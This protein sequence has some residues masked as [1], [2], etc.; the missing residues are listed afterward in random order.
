MIAK[1][2]TPQNCPRIQDDKSKYCGFLDE[3][4]LI[5]H[6]HLIPINQL[7]QIIPR[8]IDN[9]NAKSSRT[10]LTLSETMT[11]EQIRTTYEKVGRDLFGY[12]RNYCGDPASSAYE[13]LGKHYR[14]VGKEQFRNLVL[15][16]GRM[17]SGWR[18]QYIAKDAARLSKRFETVSDI[19]ATETDFNVT[20]G[21]KDSDRGVCIYVSVKNRTNT[22]GDQDWPKAILALENMANADKNKTGPLRVWYCYGKG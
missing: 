17:N 14:E 19:G 9:A 6:S 7:K 5:P 13:N 20:I 15:Q 11:E 1:T 8:A 16:K 18:Y 2:L 21:K 22:M 3:T 10:L 4:L 12:F